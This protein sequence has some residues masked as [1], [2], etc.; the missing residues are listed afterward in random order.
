MMWRVLR[1][2]LPHT[3]GEIGDISRKYQV[4]ATTSNRDRD[5]FC[6]NT[7][8]T[9]LEDALAGLFILKNINSEDVHSVFIT[10]Q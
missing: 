2:L 4:D 10:F 5:E 1:S 6:M 7:S 3:G 8:I 9:Y